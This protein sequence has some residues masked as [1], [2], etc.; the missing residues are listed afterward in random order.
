[1][2]KE[3]EFNGVTESFS[4]IAPEIQSEGIARDVESTTGPSCSPELDQPR[5]KWRSD[6][7]TITT[8]IGSPR[9][10]NMSNLRSLNR[11]R[12]MR[13]IEQIGEPTL[14]DW[15]G[16]RVCAAGLRLLD[17]E[18][19]PVGLAAMMGMSA[20]QALPSIGAVC[21]DPGENQYF[22]SLVALIEERILDQRA[23]VH[24]TEQMDSEIAREFLLLRPLHLDPSCNPGQAVQSIV[25]RLTAIMLRRLGEAAARRHIGW[26]PLDDDYADESARTE[27]SR[28]ESLGVIEEKATRLAERGDRAAHLISVFFRSPELWSLDRAAQ[29]YG[30]GISSQNWRKILS[31]NSDQIRLMFDE[32]IE[33]A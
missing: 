20:P 18:S 32:S 19:L 11:V 16:V 13:A 25:R 21:L 10:I 33:V 3:Y 29:A 17:D 15:H 27:F 24:D 26:E 30:L 31:R 9:S 8:G 2:A 14:A 28:I 5:R 22:V 12:L 6:G 7:E 1:M 23:S 4:G